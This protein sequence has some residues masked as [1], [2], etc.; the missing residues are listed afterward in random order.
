MANEIEVISAASAQ[1]LKLQ[2]QEMV[3]DGWEIK[4]VI[5]YNPH[6]IYSEPYVILERATV[7]ASIKDEAYYENQDPLVD[8]SFTRPEPK[9]K[10]ISISMG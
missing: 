10:E 9:P 2:L 1:A 8:T 4:G 3:N 5:G 7:I 6:N